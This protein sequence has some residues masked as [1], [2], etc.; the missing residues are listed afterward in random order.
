M[1]LLCL[2]FASFVVPHTDCSYDGGAGHCPC[3]LCYAMPCYAILGL[4]TT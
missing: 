4:L 3:M 1:H 2:L